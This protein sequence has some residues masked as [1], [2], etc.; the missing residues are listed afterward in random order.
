MMAGFGGERREVLKRKIQ[1][2]VDDDDR[3]QWWPPARLDLPDASF[4]GWLAA[5]LVRR[6]CTPPTPDPTTHV[7]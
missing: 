7:P 4:P 2:V 5:C 1:H 6:A 3:A